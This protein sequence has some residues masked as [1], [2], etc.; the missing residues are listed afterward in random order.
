MLSLLVRVALSREHLLLL[1]RWHFHM[2]HRV[3]LGCFAEYVPVVRVLM[4]LL[5]EDHVASFFA[6]CRSELRLASMSERGR[7][8]VRVCRLQL[9]HVV[10]LLAGD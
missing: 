1:V 2:G 3:L 10:L 4:L 6:G 5:V 7:V 9:Y 8:L